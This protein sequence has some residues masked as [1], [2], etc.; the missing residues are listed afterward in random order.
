MDRR[1][2]EP[3]TI[4]PVFFPGES[5]VLVGFYDIYNQNGDMQSLTVNLILVSLLHVES[6]KGTV[7]SNKQHLHSA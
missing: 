4:I 6:W 2:C 3:K 1:K 5:I 7:S